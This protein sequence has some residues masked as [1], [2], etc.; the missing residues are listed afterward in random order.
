M[1]TVRELA[2]TL[3][4]SLGEYSQGHGEQIDRCCNAVRVQEQI[5]GPIFVV[6]DLRIWRWIRRATR[7]HLAERLCCHKLAYEEGCRFYSRSLG[8]FYE[9]C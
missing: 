3:Y 4:T 2:M 7:L 9:Q 8:K 1:C 5:I 6:R